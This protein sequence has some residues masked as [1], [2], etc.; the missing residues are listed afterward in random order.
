MRMWMV[1][2]GEKPH[3]GDRPEAFREKHAGHWKR[4]VGPG[5]YR[6]SGDKWKKDADKK[7]DWPS[8]SP[9]LNGAIEFMWS[10]IDA[11]LDS[12]YTS[13]DAL[14][15]DCLK[16]WKQCPQAHIDKIITRLPTMCETILRKDGGMTKY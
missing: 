9:N 16:Y 15:A 2:G 8:R 6:P 3:C 1:V 4:V 5:P 10:Y 12:Y 14:K 11:R 7:Q 13:I